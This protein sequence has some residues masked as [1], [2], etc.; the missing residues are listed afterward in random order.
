MDFVNNCDPGD[1]WCLSETERLEAIFNAAQWI[2]YGVAFV[3]GILVTLYL[4]EIIW[5]GLTVE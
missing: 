1:T 3:I 2:V 5:K 4:L